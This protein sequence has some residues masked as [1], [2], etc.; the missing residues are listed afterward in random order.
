[1]PTVIDIDDASDWGYPIPQ[2]RGR[3]ELRAA[4]LHVYAGSIQSLDLAHLNAIRADIAEMRNFTYDEWTRQLGFYPDDP[5][6][7]WE[8]PGFGNGPP[9]PTAQFVA[10]TSGTIAGAALYVNKP[11]GVQSGDF[12]V[13]F[14]YAPDHTN[15][16]SAADAGTAEYSNVAD[17]DRIAVF[18]RVAGASEPAEYSF[19][20]T[21]PTSTV[22][23]ICAA[24]R[25][26]SKISA[27]ARASSNGTGVST[28]PG[29][30]PADSGYLLWLSCIDAATPPTMLTAPPNTITLGNN[31]AAPATLRLQGNDDVY[32]GAVP[33][34]TF[35][36]NNGT[37]AQRTNLTL[38]VA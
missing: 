18:T 21:G 17:T 24:F 22:S 15:N 12:L 31:T 9:I 26:A 25:N 36:W 1:M 38:M 14:V 35:F 27:S 11:A 37:A 30:N 33:A 2:Y 7:G 13:F 5:P 19:D 34:S 16:V 20:I 4:I 29:I 28:A 23:V 3:D 8:D 10:S 6:P 32:A